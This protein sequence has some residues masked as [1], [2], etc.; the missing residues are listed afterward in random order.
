[1]ALRSKPKLCGVSVSTSRAELSEAMSSIWPGA[2]KRVKGNGFGGN[3]GENVKR[4]SGNNIK[5]V[6]DDSNAVPGI[7]SLV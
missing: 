6:R 3:V 5:K 1:V 2:Y 4:V 7:R